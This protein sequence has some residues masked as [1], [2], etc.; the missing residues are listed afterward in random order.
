MVCS[1]AFYVIILTRD[2][3]FLPIYTG[4]T[5]SPRELTFNPF[6]SES[7]F[8]PAQEFLDLYVQFMHNANGAP[9]GAWTVLA[10]GTQREADPGP[11]PHGAYVP[12]DTTNMGHLLS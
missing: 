4:F 5:A 11:C 8:F 1:C 3:S 10:S 7:H 9:S 2:T 6:F 12:V